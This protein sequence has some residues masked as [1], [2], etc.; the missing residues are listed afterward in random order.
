MASGLLSHADRRP[1]KIAIDRGGTFTDIWARQDGKPDIILKLL[2]VDPSN[3]DDAPTEGIRRV[4]S[5][6]RGKNIPRGVPLPKED[7][8]FVRMGTTVATNALLERKGA[9]H[10]LLVTKGF[11]DLLKIGY[12]SRPQLFDL[13]ISKP[14]VLYSEVRE[15]DERVTVEGFD[16]D[17][18]GSMKPT[19]EVP[20]EII[21]GSSGNM[22]RILRPLQEDSVRSMLKHL[23]SQDIDTIA[24]CFAH[25]YIYP[26]HEA[27]VGELAL[28]EGFTHVSLSSAVAANMIKMVPRGS[29]SSADAYLTPE[30]KKYL[31][32]FISGFEGGHLDDARMD[33]MQSDGGLVNHKSF[34]GL[35]GIFSGPAG[36][37]VGFSRTSYNPATETPIV[38]FDMGGTSTD[39]SRYGGTFEHVFETTT[40]GITIQSPQLDINTVAAGGGSILAW[41]NGLLTV[42]PE[43]AS[44]HP[45]PACYRKNGPLAVTDANLFLGRLVPDFF[46]KFF[47]SRENEALDTEVVKRKFAE[48]T[49][50]I[51]VD[52]KRTMTPEDVAYGFLDVAN[53]AM[54]RPIRALTEAKGYEIGK[55]QLAVFGGAGGQHACEIASKLGISTVTI[56]R[57]SSI[58]SAYGM[59]LAD[60]VQEAQEPVNVVYANQAILDLDTKLETL[61]STVQQNLWEQGV[62]TEDMSY[63]Y[64]LNMRYRGTETAMMILQPVNGNFKEAFLEQ[65]L[66]EFNFVFPEARDVLVDD[67]RVRGI[68]RSGS[69]ESDAA[70]LSNELRNIS[71]ENAASN[72]V[73]RTIKT[74]FQNH[75]CISTPVYFL[76]R[77]LPGTIVGGPAMILDN[78]QSILIIPGAEAKILSAHVVIHVPHLVKSDTS[79]TTVDPIQ[80]STFSHR[81]M[82]IA[83]QMGRILQKTSVSLNIKERLDFSCAIFGPDAGLVANAPHVPVHLGSMSYAVK[84]QHELLNGKMIPGDVLVSNH[85]EAGGAHLPDITVITPVFESSGKDIAF[86][87]ASRGHHTD[88]GGLGGTSMPPNSTELWQEGAAIKSF[89]LIHGG[90]FF[91]EEGMK[92]ILSAPGRYPGCMGSRRLDDNLS[93]LKAQV[94]A[95]RK[96]MLLIQS[97]MEE[98]SQEVVQFYM[99]AIQKNAESSVRKYLQ[100]TRKTKGPQFSAIDQMDNGSEIVLSIS[101]RENGSATFDFTGT[102]PEMY[103]NMNGPPSI[104]YSAIMYCLRLLI[105]TDIPMNQGCLAPIDIILPKG[106]FLNPSSGAAVCASNTQTSQRVCDVILTAFQAA[107][108]SNGCMNCIGFFGEVPNPYGGPEHSF[109]FGETICGGSGATATASGADAVHVHMTNTRITDVETLER[110]YPVVLRQFSIRS[111]SG[112]SGFHKGGEGVIRDIEC[113]VP[114]RF[115][116]ITERR[117]V[118]PCGMAGGL[119]AAKGKNY[120]VRRVKNEVGGDHH[121]RWVNMGPKNMVSM[122]PGDRCVVYTPG[123]GGWGKA[124]GTS[125]NCTKAAVLPAYPRAAG[126]IVAWNTTQAQAN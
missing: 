104:T 67:V 76:E 58:L 99:H 35:K 1:V 88:I 39:V 56:H 46:P 3:Y 43:S 9:R 33:F 47:G 101:I 79:S 96:G 24:V 109:A 115:S 77:L 17:I 34:S 94:A 119:D 70:K 73:E 21:Q 10:A 38:G 45:G 14:E 78:T 29:S 98:Y 114:I 102:A 120:W 106:T 92:K 6:I 51:N 69:V 103:S 52:T 63:E 49:A 25:S 125:D 87:V 75:G 61:R 71:F 81:F 72:T 20:G 30:I 74:Y 121:E 107:A 50:T 91:D 19:T 8:E 22:I 80:L 11:R 82:S 53:E 57:Y 117:A 26:D 54:C 111:G 28:E 37:V 105:G 83:E 27:R 86:Y 66:R 12:Q 55:H 60:V 90:G 15:V 2:S 36:G 97:L 93:D 62:K 48:L 5:I 23:R 116:V 124:Y 41:R 7:L 108:Q 112:G 122:Q 113:R 13:N 16:E 44:S 68:G 40:A 85:P 4:L 100:E 89:R 65:H 95:N 31:A 123:G 118:A 64:Y 59:A 84:Y 110:R 42:G 32:G 18:F 126:S